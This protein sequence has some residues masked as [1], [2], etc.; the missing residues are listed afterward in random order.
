[1][2]EVARSDAERAQAVFAE[3]RESG[4]YERLRDTA[5]DIWLITDEP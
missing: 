3:L 5:V 1:V 4:L 2:T